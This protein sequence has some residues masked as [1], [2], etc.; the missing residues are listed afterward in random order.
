MWYT[1]IEA[2][3][4]HLNNIKKHYPTANI[5]LCIENSPPEKHLEWL[6]VFKDTYEI[7]HVHFMY[8]D[9]YNCTHDT[10]RDEDLKRGGDYLE[11]VFRFAAPNEDFVFIVSPD[12]FFKKT[13]CPSLNY[14][15]SGYHFA[16]S[17][18][19]SK[20]TAEM[21]YTYYS[22]ERM[23]ASWVGDGSFFKTKKYKL[24]F[25]VYR[26][27]IEKLVKE[28]FTPETRL[29]LDYYMGLYTFFSDKVSNL[30]EYMV[31]IGHLY[32]DTEYDIQD[33][34]SKEEYTYCVHGLKKYYVSF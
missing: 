11:N 24:K 9:D 3:T 12:I 34:L 16:D 6:P 15:I 33:V 17:S 23:G 8:K 4:H 26:E 22:R 25:K 5:S 29:P 27:V 13:Y 21:Y 7:E 1:D 32:K 10:T 30:K 28:T 31:D 18:F 19:F 14:D 2:A 20:T